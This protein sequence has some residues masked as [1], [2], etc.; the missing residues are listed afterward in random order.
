LSGLCPAL[1]GI[2]CRWSIRDAEV[3]AKFWI[4]RLH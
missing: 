1:A 2:W 4:V 3:G